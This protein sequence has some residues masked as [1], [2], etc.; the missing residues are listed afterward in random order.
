MTDSDA[1]QP[2][3]LAKISYSGLNARQKENFN[4]QKVSAVLADYGYTTFRLTDDWQGAD[5]LALHVSGVVLRVQLKSR[6]A[7]SKKYVDKGL[8]VAFPYGDAWF[9]YPHDEVLSQILQTKTVGATRSWQRGGY[10]F[11]YLSARILKVLGPYQ[12]SGDTRA[13]K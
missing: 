11:P 6:L 12:I 9:L 4:F 13:V 5:F 1:H 2:S 7:F 10:S 3:H 8:H